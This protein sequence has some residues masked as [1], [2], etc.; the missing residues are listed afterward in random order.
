MT[1]AH[2]EHLWVPMAHT[3]HLRVG[4]AMCW[5]WQ[6]PAALWDCTYTD[7]NTVLRALYDVLCWVLS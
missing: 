6:L 2:T 5:Y 7:G 4:K 1:K 3:E